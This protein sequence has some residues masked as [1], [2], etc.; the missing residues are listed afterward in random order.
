MC[1]SN[2]GHSLAHKR[3]HKKTEPLKPRW[4]KFLFYYIQ[5][6]FMQAHLIL[7]FTWTSACEQKS[8]FLFPFH[9]FFEKV[10]SN[11]IN[12]DD[13]ELTIVGSFVSLF[14]SI[15]VRYAYGLDGATHLIWQWAASNETLVHEETPLSRSP[16]LLQPIGTDIQR[17]NSL[18]LVKLSCLWNW[19]LRYNDPHATLMF[20]QNTLVSLEKLTWLEPKTSQN[21]HKDGAAY[22]LGVKL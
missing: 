7:I 16:N 5:A 4:R 22:M 19:S 15:L 17:L 12:F 13:S 20:A 21:F 9:C 18:A 6:H 3:L 2:L 10:F 8:F 11:S 1:H 14:V